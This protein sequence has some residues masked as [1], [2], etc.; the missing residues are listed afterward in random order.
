V[1]GQTTSAQE[2]PHEFALSRVWP[3]PAASRTA[4]EFAVA[5]N[6]EVRLSVID[7]AGHEV[8]VLAKGHYPPGRYQA[9]W[10]A[11]KAHAAPGVYFLRYWTPSFEQIRRIVLT[12]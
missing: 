12:R 11:A 5:A 7:V 2:I 10:D 9:I 1:F 6:A 8:S 4:I 3:N